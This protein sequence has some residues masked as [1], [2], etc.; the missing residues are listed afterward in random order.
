MELDEGDIAAAAIFTAASNMFS[1]MLAALQIALKQERKAGF[2][3][4]GRQLEPP[5]AHLVRPALESFI[6]A[7]PTVG[8]QLGLTPDQARRANEVYLQHLHSLR[9]EVLEAIRKFEI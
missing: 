2:T 3:E 6:A 1:F 4:D 9:D 7:H 8:D 5:V